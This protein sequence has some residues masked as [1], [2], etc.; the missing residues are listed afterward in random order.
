M[1][2]KHMIL[3]RHGRIVIQRESAEKLPPLRRRPLS[4]AGVT[5]CQAARDVVQHWLAQE[6][7]TIHRLWA[8]R[9]QRATQTAALVFGDALA[10]QTISLRD[11]SPLQHA[12]PDAVVAM[13]LHGP[14]FLPVLSAVQ[15]TPPDLADVFGAVVVLRQEGDGPWCLIACHPQANGAAQV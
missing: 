1:S 2:V 10:P 14:T 15:P 4:P 7:R 5:E 3:V 6:G 11:A 8:E 13:V 9:S 12:I